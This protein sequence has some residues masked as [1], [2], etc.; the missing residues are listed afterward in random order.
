MKHF[1]HIWSTQT[2]YEGSY[3]ISIGFKGRSSI[4]F[5]NPLSSLLGDRK[6]PSR[7]VTASIQHLRKQL[8]YYSTLV[9]GVA[10]SCVYLNILQYIYFSNYCLW[11]K[12]STSVIGLRPKE[13]LVIK[14]ATL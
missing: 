7:F 3:E 11:S 6:I 14:S 1:M 12:K 13:L 10:A 5:A 4:S 2:F 8:L 9:Y